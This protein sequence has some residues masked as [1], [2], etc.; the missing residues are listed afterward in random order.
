MGRNRCSIVQSEDRHEDDCGDAF[1]VLNAVLVA[2][3][4]E[5]PTVQSRPVWSF[6]DYFESA[7]HP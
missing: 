4:K 3:Q 6:A 5:T 7:C 2:I 1:I